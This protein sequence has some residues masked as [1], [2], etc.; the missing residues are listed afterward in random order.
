[1][2]KA[3]KITPRATRVNSVTSHCNKAGKAEDNNQQSLT[4]FH[5]AMSSIVS[6]G[7]GLDRAADTTELCPRIVTTTPSNGVRQSR[8]F[9]VTPRTRSQSSGHAGSVRPA[10]VVHATEAR[11]ASNLNHFQKRARSPLA[12]PSDGLVTP[13]SGQASPDRLPKRQRLNSRVPSSP[14]DT[15]DYHATKDSRSVLS[16]DAASCTVPPGFRQIRSALH[17]SGSARRKIPFIVAPNSVFERQRIG[18]ASHV[19]ETLHD[20]TTPTHRRDK[21]HAEEKQRFREYNQILH[22]GIDFVKGVYQVHVE[23]PN[24]V[25]GD[26]SRLVDCS[27]VS[28]LDL[29]NTDTSST[30]LSGSHTPATLYEPLDEKRV[31]RIKELELVRKKMTNEHGCAVAKAIEERRKQGYECLVTEE[32]LFPHIDRELQQLRGQPVAFYDIPREVT[33]QYWD[34]HPLPKD[35]VIDVPGKSRVTV[36]RRLCW[37]DSEQPPPGR[38]ES[39]PIPRKGTMAWR[40][41][42]AALKRSESYE[43]G[44]MKHDATKLAKAAAEAERRAKLPRLIGLA[45]N[46]ILGERLGAIGLLELRRPQPVFRRP[47]AK[48]QHSIPGIFGR[49]EPLQRIGQIQAMIP[50]GRFHPRSSEVR[51]D[52]EEADDKRTTS[53][54]SLHYP[55]SG[56][57]KVVTPRYVTNSVPGR[58]LPGARMMK[59]RARTA[60]NPRPGGQETRAETKMSQSQTAAKL[61]SDGQ[62]SSVARTSLSMYGPIEPGSNRTL[63]KAPKKTLSSQ[64][65]SNAKADRGSCGNVAPGHSLDTEFP[66]VMTSGVKNSKAD[67]LGQ[68]SSAEDLGEQSLVLRAM[69]LQYA[70]QQ[71]CS[72]RNADSWMF[73]KSAPVQSHDSPVVAAR[74]RGRQP[75]FSQTSVLQGERLRAPQQCVAIQPRPR[76][77]RTREMLDMQLAACIASGAPRIDAGVY[78]QLPS[79]ENFD[80]ASWQSMQKQPSQYGPFPSQEAFEAQVDFVTQKYAHPSSELR[81]V[82][83]HQSATQ[84]AVLH[85]PHSAATT[86]NV[87]HSHLLR[88]SIADDPTSIAQASYV[89]GSTIASV[90]SVPGDLGALKKRAPSVQNHIVRAE[91]AAPLLNAAAPDVAVSKDHTSIVLAPNV[92]APKISSLQQSTQTIETPDAQS[93]IFWRPNVSGPGGLASNSDHSTYANGGRVAYVNLHPRPPAKPKRGESSSNP[94]RTIADRRGS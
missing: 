56:G 11:T 66:A 46:T 93:V 77:P 62:L 12:A 76:S 35:T 86:G 37:A 6:N 40:E 80:Y 15:R 72:L 34:L 67:G 44:W 54:P 59:K 68:S 92:P 64:I 49:D 14:L 65:L 16:H 74:T 90:A 31:A 39:V 7:V 50:G 42:Q 82:D 32:L 85:R 22:E 30:D 43:A 60:T 13:S 47:L 5:N 91:H 45:P 27:N 69:T 28:Y 21:R 63:S 19:P 8:R 18:W 81:D 38:E 79:F 1:M 26:R 10:M 3:I 88:G 53:A 58:P 87:P 23:P 61:L 2:L 94:P 29:L 57:L 52:T 78:D 41:R 4:D 84:P 89:Q 51:Q 25:S 71:E 20:R 9:D 48:A 36:P 17:E 73:D 83:D 24:H 75:P 33:Y 55:L 70:T